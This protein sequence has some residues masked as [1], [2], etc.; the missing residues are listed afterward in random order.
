MRTNE[1]LRCTAELVPCRFCMF[2]SHSRVCLHIPPSPS[3]ALHCNIIV[4][5]SKRKKRRRIALVVDKT[6]AISLYD[7]TA[8][9]ASIPQ[10]QSLATI[11]VDILDDNGN[12]I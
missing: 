11:S 4:K 6:V 5:K 3:T 8:A 7:G 9:A 12:K 2:F 10:R 1:P